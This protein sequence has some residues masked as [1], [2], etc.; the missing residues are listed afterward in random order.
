M[1][2]VES[3]HPRAAALGIAPRLDGRRLERVE[4]IGKNLLLTFE[5]D[6][7]LR[8]HLRMRGAGTSRGAARRVT[9]LPVARAAGRAPSGGALARPGAR[10][11]RRRRRLAGLGPDILADPPDLDAMIA[12][13]RAADQYRE[14]GEALLDQRLVAGIGNIWRRRR[15][16]R[17][18]R[19][20]VDDASATSPTTSCGASLEA[21]A[22]LMRA[23]A[24]RAAWSTGAP[25]LRAG[26][27]GRRSRPPAGRR[28]ADGLLV[29]GL[30]GRNG[31]AARNRRVTAGHGR[32]RRRSTARCATSASAR[33]SRS[34][35]SSKPAPTFPSRSTEHGG[36]N[37][38]TL[39]E[40]RP[41]VGAFVEQRAGWLGAREDAL[42]ALAAL[43]D[44]P[45]AGD[46]RARARERAA[47]G[48]RGASP[49][50]PRFRCSF[51]R[52]SAAAASTGRTPRS[53]RLRRARALALRR[54]A[55]RTRRSPRSSAS[56]PAARSSSARGLRVRPAA[57]GEFA[58]HWPEASRLLPR[59]YGREVGPHARS[60]ELARDLDAAAPQVPGRADRVRA[61][62]QRP[63]AR[64]PGCDRGRAGALRAA[65]LATVRRQARAA[66]RRPGAARGG[67]RGSTRSAAGS[68][69][70]SSAA[71]EARRRSRPARGAR[72]LRDRALPPRA[73]AGGRAARGARARSSAARTAR[74]RP[75]CARPRCS[76]R[77]RATGP[78]C[79]ARCAALVDGD[80]PGARAEDAVRRALVEAL[81]ADRA[82]S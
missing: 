69:P 75:R 61:R 38:P 37:R 58:A 4:A 53:T 32:S 11:R 15:S 24:R 28:R 26:A 19:L 63:A 62:D 49:H 81:L 68:P 12:R 9:G 76:A 73:A 40:Y 66:A 18:R 51:G 30:P 3:P 60:L 64:D 43:K 67:R 54:T 71:S 22:A 42:A 20:A 1:L 27:A 78:S 80:G 14:I 6:L 72:A 70:S 47:R 74:G 46:L 34:R 45:A 39:Y 29:P 55:R 50:D 77:P 13:L 10:A 2:A 21:A 23:R 36:P 33:S 35:R 65:R 31:P 48:G 56:R 41:L 5:G 16:S 82:R 52:P 57:A 44:E 17:A 25:G 7:V 79:W 59:D 8:S